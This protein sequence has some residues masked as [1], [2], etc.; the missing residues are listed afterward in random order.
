MNE[1]L[2]ETLSLAPVFP[3]KNLKCNNCYA[4]VIE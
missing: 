3:L 4:H 1:N 2:I